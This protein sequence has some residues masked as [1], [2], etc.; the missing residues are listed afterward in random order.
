ML[1]EDKRI[2]ILHATLELVAEKGFHDAP[3]S[4]IAQRAGVAAGTIYRYF[5]NKD[6]L[7]NELYLSVESS[8]AERLLQGY[9][10]DASIRDRFM[11]LGVGVLHYFISRPSEFKFVEQFHNSPYGTAFRR[12]RILG[13]PQENDSNR[14]CE[15]FRELFT[16]ALEIEV[17][18]QIPL[19]I[20]FDLAFGPIISVARNH[21]LGFITLDDELIKQIVSACWDGLK[22]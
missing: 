17:V 13:V 11:H 21:V 14:K 6:V 7:I 15:I 9:L 18:K 4:L 8:M 2:L 16:E 12:D 5:E 19:I 3:C 10:P 22:R 1:R 20:L